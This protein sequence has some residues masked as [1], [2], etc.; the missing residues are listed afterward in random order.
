MDNLTAVSIA[1]SRPPMGIQT[2]QTIASLPVWNACRYDAAKDSIDEAF[3]VR[4]WQICG[5][6]DICNQSRLVMPESLSYTAGVETLS[7]IRRELVHTL[8]PSNSRILGNF[9]LT[10]AE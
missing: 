3:G 1:H 7:L 10:A 6:G 5:S 2:I 9:N 8:P 4:S